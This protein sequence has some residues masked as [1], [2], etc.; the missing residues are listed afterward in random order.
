MTSALQKCKINLAEMKTFT[1][2]AAHT[3]DQIIHKTLIG[4]EPWYASEVVEIERS[5]P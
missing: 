5:Q 2:T 4:F 3:A 1:F